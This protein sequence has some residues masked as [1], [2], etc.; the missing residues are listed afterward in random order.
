MIL[1]FAG[2]DNSKFIDILEKC[3]VKNI[4][5]SFY[6]TKNSENLKKIADRFNVFV[7]SGGYTARKM[8]VNIDVKRYGEFLKK[9]KD[10]IFMAANL[11]V[12]DLNIALENQKY[13][14]QFYPIIPVFHYS[15]YA[16]KRQDL[17][18]EF[19]KNNQ[20]IAVGGIAGMNID[21]KSVINFLN[22]CFRTT[23]KYKTKV[24]GFGI[25]ALKYLV[26]YPFYSVDSTSW[27]TGGQYGQLLKWDSKNFDMETSIHY[28]DKDSFLKHNFNINL[29]ES[30]KGRLIHNVGELLKC[31]KEITRLWEERGILYE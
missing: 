19:C 3:N 8:G 17:L 26:E 18:D 2:A 28:S 30:Y 16:N 13:L 11:D 23:I 14:Q 15:E 5:I 6:W 22:F 20:Y 4:L 21:T 29:I 12:Y 31:E 25:T 27:L 7:D 24:H 10:R 1:F 9:N